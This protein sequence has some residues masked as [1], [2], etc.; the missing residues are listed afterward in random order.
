[1]GSQQ[2]R[3]PIRK[4]M[5]EAVRGPASDSELLGLVPLGP[6]V[7]TAAMV[8]DEV[9][10]RLIEDKLQL[11]STSEVECL[12]G[13]LANLQREDECFQELIGKAAKLVFEQPMEK[14]SLQMLGVFGR[15][16]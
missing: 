8:F 4:A 9:R 12:L 6:D 5:A 10:Q 11:Q 14:L 13:C 1:M 7:D 2:L 3:E 15:L 16:P